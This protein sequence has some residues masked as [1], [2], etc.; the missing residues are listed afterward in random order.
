MINRKIVKS[1]ASR[2][3]PSHAADQ[4]SHY[5]LVGSFHHGMGFKPPATI[6]IRSFLA[7]VMAP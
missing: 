1:N 7:F 6:V 4:A 3:Q 5:A 2:V